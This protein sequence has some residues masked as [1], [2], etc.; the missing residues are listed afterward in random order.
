M[1]KQ[2]K[3]TTLIACPRVHDT[4]GQFLLIEA[5]HELP[6]WVTPARAQNRLWIKSGRLNLV[7]IDYKSPGAPRKRRVFD[8]DD[9]FD[10][11]KVEDENDAWIDHLKA[12]QVVRDERIDTLASPSLENAAFAR[13][14]VY[15]AALASH[16]HTFVAYLP[17]PLAAVCA[18]TSTP[19]RHRHTATS[20]TQKAIEAFACRDAA[21]TR[22]AQKMSRF[23]PTDTTPISITV[24]R[25]AYAQMQGQRF[26]PPRTFHPDSWPSAGRER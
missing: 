14:N 15:P 24:T 7:P 3:V 9:A 16:Q 18:H 5:A 21:G 17:P 26:Y 12:I 10:D 4:D 22:A 19:S 23:N 1:I 13:I 8:V 11:L 2:C 6:Q 25:T 20:L